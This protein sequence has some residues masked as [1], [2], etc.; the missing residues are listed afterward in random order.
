MSPQ[1]VCCSR[2]PP[3]E[4][5][6]AHLSLSPRP[7]TQSCSGGGGW[8]AC[9]L[10]LT[11]PARCTK[12]HRGKAARLPVSISWRCS[13][14]CARVLIPDTSGVPA[15]RKSNQSRIQPGAL[16]LEGGNSR[17]DFSF[18]TFEVLE[19]CCDLPGREP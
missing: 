5:I 18:L 1:R 16:M 8:S 3:R 2:E 14:S 7:M 10:I 17:P 4:R 9:G 15:R 19:L 6:A 11:E 12:R 13:E